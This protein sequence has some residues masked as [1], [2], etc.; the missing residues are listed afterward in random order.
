[1]GLAF[2]AIFLGVNFFLLHFN[3]WFL[4]PP[5][6][7]LVGGFSPTHLKNIRQNGIISPGRGENK[8]CLKP[9]PSQL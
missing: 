6:A 2:F 8:K 3:K 4:G 5:C 7:Q 9:P 1:M